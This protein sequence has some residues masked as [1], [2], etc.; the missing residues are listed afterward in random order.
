AAGPRRGRR[1]PRSRCASARRSG[2]G[3]RSV[4]GGLR[5]TRPCSDPFPP[6]ARCVARHSDARGNWYR[7]TK[8]SQPA[9][10]LGPPLVD[11]RSRDGSPRMTPMEVQSMLEKHRLWLRRKSGGIRLMLALCDL[12]GYDFSDAMLHGAK[13]SGADMARAMLPR[14]TLCEADLFAAN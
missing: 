5:R 4:I 6:P 7:F 12:H 13:F 9:C 8:P 11:D 3:S 2:D 10:F 14:A 1:R